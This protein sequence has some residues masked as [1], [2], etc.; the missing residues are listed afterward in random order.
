MLRTNQSITNERGALALL[1]GLVPNRDLT[2]HETFRIAEL[3]ANRL[4]GHSN[5]RTAAVPSEIVTRVPRIR[6]SRERGLPVSGSAHWNGHYWLIAVCAEDHPVRQRF[7][8][9]HEFK[10]VLDHT[11]RHRLYRD[12]RGTSAHEH[13]ERVADYFAACVLMPKRVVKRLWGEG[14]Q[15]IPRLAR[16]LQVSQ[17]AL[18]Y[19]LEQLGLRE[20]SRR[21][22]PPPRVVDD[23]PLSVAGVRP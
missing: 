17:P 15:D 3:Q 6:V 9:M 19:R 5:V 2:V 7:S 11:T 18:R 10:H 20:R 4:L 23:A 22:V 14:H 1:R 8:L 16:M 21:C 12:R 13:A